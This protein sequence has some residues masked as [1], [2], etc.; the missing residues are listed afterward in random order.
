MSLERDNRCAECQQPLRMGEEWLC[1][2]CL[3]DYLICLDPNGRMTCYD[4]PESD[5]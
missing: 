3:P 4:P 1:A 2:E 5:P